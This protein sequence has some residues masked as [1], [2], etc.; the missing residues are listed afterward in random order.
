MAS[1]LG[2]PGNELGVT[3]PRHWPWA[4]AISALAWE[5]GTTLIA[6]QLAT[7]HRANL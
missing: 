1:F 4:I 2:W 7:A 5:W 6:Q 3:G